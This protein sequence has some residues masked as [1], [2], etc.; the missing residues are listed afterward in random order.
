M[1]TMGAKERAGCSAASSPWPGR[2]RATPETGLLSACPGTCS[3]LA[4][5]P[6]PPQ[7]QMPCSL[8]LLV[9]FA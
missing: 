2:G 8:L 9:S 5:E 6:A 4:G 1:N 3:A 7:L